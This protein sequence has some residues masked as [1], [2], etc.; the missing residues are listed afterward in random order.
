[1]ETD[2]PKPPSLILRNSAGPIYHGWVCF[3]ACRRNVAFVN[4]RV[5]TGRCVI[6]ATKPASSKIDGVEVE[7]EVAASERFEAE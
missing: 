7:A 3:N 4:T 5:V 2:C 6:G 1:M